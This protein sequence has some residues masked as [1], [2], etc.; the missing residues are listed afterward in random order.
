MVAERAE[1]PVDDPHAKL[2]QAFIAEYLQQHGYSAAA[3]E[4]LPVDEVQEVLK[5]ASSYASG[6]LCEMESRAH[7]VSD[8]HAAL[9]ESSGT[10]RKRP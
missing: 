4:A 2:E 8:L 1:I 3:L 5:R 7:Y 10:T 6:R 9:A